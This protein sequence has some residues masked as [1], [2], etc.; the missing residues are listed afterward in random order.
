MKSEFKTNIPLIFLIAENEW[1]ESSIDY[2]YYKTSKGLKEIAPFVSGIGPYINQ[3]Y[4]ETNDGALEPTEI[5][6]NA[7]KY[8]LV[9]HPYTHRIDSLPKGISNNSEFFNFIYDNLKVDGVFSDF[10][11]VAMEHSKK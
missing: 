5:V 11:D 8:G 2:N 4:D 1:N 7:T 9:V 10:G 6:K 3:L